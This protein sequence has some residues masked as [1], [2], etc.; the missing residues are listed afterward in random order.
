MSVPHPSIPSS[1]PPPFGPTLSIDSVQMMD[2][3]DYR[4]DSIDSM[5]CGPCDQ[6]DSIE[7][8]SLSSALYHSN[9]EQTQIP[10]TQPLDMG[11]PLQSPTEIGRSHSSGGS[12]TPDP[13][14][15][16]RHDFMRNFFSSYHEQ[17]SESFPNT[18]STSVARFAKSL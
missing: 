11:L 6:I 9:V 2:C 12:Y 1:H 18:G 5:D 16:A 13:Q 8:E 10:H 14:V 17:H 7:M 15:L 4:M 3:V